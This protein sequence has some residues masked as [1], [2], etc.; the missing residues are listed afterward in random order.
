M[1]EPKLEEAPKE[2]KIEEAPKEPKKVKKKSRI[3]KQQS[4]E[5]IETVTLRSHKRE[6]PPKDEMAELGSGVVLTERI[7]SK[8]RKITAHSLPPTEKISLKSHKFEKIPQEE[9]VRKS[10]Q[11]IEHL[12]AIFLT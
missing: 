2:P 5:P 10:N 11:L 4:P 9:K 1:G 12:H 7:E 8:V 3:I 6:A